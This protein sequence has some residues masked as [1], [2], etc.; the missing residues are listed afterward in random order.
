MHHPCKS[1]LDWGL[2]IVGML[3][4]S[5]MKDGKVSFQTHFMHGKAGHMLMRLWI[6]FWVFCFLVCCVFFFFFLKRSL[7]T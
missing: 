7:A 3:S 6:F 5:V 1:G 4:R 2:F